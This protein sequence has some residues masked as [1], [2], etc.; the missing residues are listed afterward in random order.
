MML[1]DEELEELPALTSELG[2]DSDSYIDDRW[3]EADSELD[4][5]DSEVDDDLICTPVPQ[6][7]QRKSVTFGRAEVWE[8]EMEEREGG[9]P[10]R[11][12]R[13]RC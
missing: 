8:R 11:K 5:S 13:C 1:T 9:S 6:T 10:T 4:M 2:D 7:K 3:S 12:P